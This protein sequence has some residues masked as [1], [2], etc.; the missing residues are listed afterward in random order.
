MKDREKLSPN[1]KELIRDRAQD[2]ND[3]EKEIL[4]C[5]IDTDCPAGFYC[6]DG[7]CVPILAVS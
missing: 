2:I 4:Y 1:L 7:R 6:E 5:S 3:K